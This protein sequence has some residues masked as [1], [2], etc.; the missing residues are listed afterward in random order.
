MRWC[1]KI[2]MFCSDIEDEEIEMCGC[3]GECMGCEDCTDI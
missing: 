1:N 2:N 3:D